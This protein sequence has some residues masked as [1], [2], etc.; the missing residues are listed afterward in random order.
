MFL[1][2][3]YFFLFLFWYFVKPKLKAVCFSRILTIKVVI[4]FYGIPLHW[5]KIILN[6]LLTVNS[7]IL[8][9]LLS[10]NL[11]FFSFSGY[12]SSFKVSLLIYLSYLSCMFLD[13]PPSYCYLVFYHF[14]FKLP[15]CLTFN[16]NY[17]IF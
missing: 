9:R 12:F 10:V 4:L 1:R 8:R 17:S 7:I 16:E 13:K 14:I 3:V 11:I 5:F 15:Q 6:C 2:F